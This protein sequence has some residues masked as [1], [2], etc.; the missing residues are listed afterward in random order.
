VIS[1]GVSQEKS[2]GQKK[3]SFKVLH[4][5]TP[6]DEGVPKVTASSQ[7]ELGSEFGSSA[8][9]IGL[10]FL[11]LTD[12]LATLWPQQNF[13]LIGTHNFYK[14]NII[15]RIIFFVMDARSCEMIL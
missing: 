7:L 12:K 13:Q 14:K 2:R 1:D 9:S 8:Q 4:V 10:L 5:V 6:K 15:G 11:P 3:K